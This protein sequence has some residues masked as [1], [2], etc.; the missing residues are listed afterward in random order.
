MLETQSSDNHER[1]DGDKR[2]RPRLGF[3]GVGWIGQH[4]LKSI[5]DARRAEIVGL[6]DLNPG[7]VAAAALEVP[8]ADV[9]ESL[10]ELLRMDLDGLVIATPT[11][12]HAEQAT[13]A[14]EA[15]LAVFCQK[16]L[17][18]T[19][20]ETREVIETARRVDRLL[21]VDMSYR[22]VRAI[23]TIKDMIEAGEIGE[24]YA[25]DLAFHNA[26]GPDKPWY[27][28]PKLAGGGCVID[29]GIHLIDMALWMSASEIAGVSSRLFAQGKR[30]LPEDDRLE[31]YA[32]VRVDLASG[33]TANLACSWHL[34]AGR[35]A[36]IRASFYGTKGGL[37]VTNVN[38][39]FYDFTAEHFSG[40]ARKT[41]VEPPDSWGGR[42]VVAWA[43]RLSESAAFDP[44]IESAASVARVIDAIYEGRE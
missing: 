14:L 42:A 28:D 7:V 20:R 22:S 21:A 41:L 17:G 29:L 32:A 31:D 4:R 27:Y 11:A 2:P 15:N 13:A 43:E 34:P 39:S 25:M 19:E 3:L 5:A 18:R 33:A 36:V 1:Q 26:Y 9:R 10:E 12:L 30:I 8:G 6:A 44:G 40:T 38:G 37:A 35:D 16:P 24:L 23:R